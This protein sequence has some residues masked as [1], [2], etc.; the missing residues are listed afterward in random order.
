MER[1]NRL[2][3]CIVIQYNL[4]KVSRKQIASE[5]EETVFTIIHKYQT[6]NLLS[7]ISTNYSTSSHISSRFLQ[8]KAL[9][10]IVFTWPLS[11]LSPRKTEIIQLVYSGIK[12]RASE[13]RDI[14]RI[15]FCLFFC[16]LFPGI[17]IDS[18]LYVR[19]SCR[20]PCFFSLIKRAI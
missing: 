9:G 14:S 16:R 20:S 1:T 11:L 4:K 13:V 19:I 10:E 3:H 12:D 17:S 15:V 6:P 2:F 8:I 18:W 7:T 5:I